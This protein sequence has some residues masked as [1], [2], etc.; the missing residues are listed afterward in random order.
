MNIPELNFYLLNE[1]TRESETTTYLDVCENF[2]IGLLSEAGVPCI[3]DPGSMIVKMA[4]LKNIEVI[5]LVGPS[6]IILAL[7]ASGFNGQ[8]FAFNG[9]LPI[10]RPE[11]NKAIK[12]LEKKALLEN[13]TQI[14]IETPYRNIQLLDD[15]LKNCT[16]TTK[17]CIACDL[18]LQNQYIKCCTIK[19]WKNIKPDIHKRPAIFLIY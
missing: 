5:P 9:Y 11:R 14:F 19:E 8:S 3:A 12:Q 16:D 15:L 4:H 17:L 10:A 1:H 13:Q 7:M 18:T 2:S 6:S